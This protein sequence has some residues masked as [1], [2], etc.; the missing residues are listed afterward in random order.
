LVD[1]LCQVR[2]AGSK[3]AALL[4]AMFLAAACCQRVDTNSIYL[5]ANGSVDQA[6]IFT[7]FVE[8]EFYWTTTTNN[9]TT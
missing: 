3:V 2:F 8:S 9:N 5:K 1:G 4:T 7:T 6:V